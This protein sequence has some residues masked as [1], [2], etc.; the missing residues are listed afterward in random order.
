MTTPQVSIRAE[1]NPGPQER[2]LLFRLIL[3]IPAAIVQGLLTAGW[4][5]LSFFIWLIT[6]ILGRMPAP[7]F[8]ATAAP[9]ARG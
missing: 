6:L 4:Y 1:P 8:D 7:L 5:V 2:R 9:C 3:I